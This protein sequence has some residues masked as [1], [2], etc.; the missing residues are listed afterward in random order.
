MLL[1]THK[2]PFKN[3]W[4]LRERERVYSDEN[5]SELNQS[6]ACVIETKATL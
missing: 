1:K 4:C 3:I 2:Q 5:Q 6:D